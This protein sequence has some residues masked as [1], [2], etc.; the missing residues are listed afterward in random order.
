MVETNEKPQDKVET[1]EGED[2]LEGAIQLF[3]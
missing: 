1:P 2:Y 3:D